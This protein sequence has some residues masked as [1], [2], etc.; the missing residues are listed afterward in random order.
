MQH[1]ALFLQSFTYNIK[2]KNTKLHTN[3]DALSRLPVN[4][5]NEY[6]YDVTDRFEIFQIETLPITLHVLAKET[7]KDP[8][9]KILLEGLRAGK[10]EIFQIETLPITL[11][12]LAK[13]TGKDPQLKILLEG[14]RA[15]KQVDARSR[16]NIPQIEFCL[17]NGCM[18]RQHMAVI[19]ESLRKRVLDELHSAHFGMVKM[20]LLARGHCWWP[21]IS[22]DIE[23]LC[24]NCVNCL[25]KGRESKFE[26]TFTR[27]NGNL[28]VYKKD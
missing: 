24:K 14:L 22:Y 3:A 10:F 5:T 8:Q 2:Y 11:H 1:Y 21:G 12:V 15:G 19:P 17:Q 7:G 25:M 26:I 9:L 18:F 27:I 13:E 16:F 28:D 20:K 23:E 6:N 4:Q